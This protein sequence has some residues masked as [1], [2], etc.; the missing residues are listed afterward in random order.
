[1]LEATSWPDRRTGG[2][3]GI[4]TLAGGHAAEADGRS[5]PVR[6]TIT[7]EM[8][9]GAVSHRLGAAEN[10]LV[11]DYWTTENTAVWTPESSPI[12]RLSA[13][14]TG[15]PEAKAIRITPF[16]ARANAAVS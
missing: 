11:I 9:K 3:T 6:P 5:G 2:G 4:S 13:T 7:G 12:I 1:M 8:A 16:N 14:V 10:H 15:S